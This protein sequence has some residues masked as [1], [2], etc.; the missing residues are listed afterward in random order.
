MM[1][2]LTKEQELI[3]E[4]VEKESVK[5]ALGGDTSYDVEK[6]KSWVDF[7][8][9]LIDLK[10]PEIIICPSPTGIFEVAEK[11]YGYKY[12]KGDVIDYNG[13]GFDS[14]WTSFYIA[15]EKIG[16]DFSDI[17]E[18]SKW[19]LLLETGVWGTRLFEEIAF[20]CLRPSSV[21]VNSND[22]LHCE[23]GKAI[24]WLDG[25][26]F[27]YLNGVRMEEDQVMTPAEKID[28]QEIIKEQ[29]V[30]VRRELIR[31][32]GIE[33]FIQK[34]GAK[35]LDKQ[36]DYKLLSVYLSEQVP[37]TRYLKMKNPSLGTYHVEGVE[38][39]TVEEAIDFR[40]KDILKKGE[41]W[42]PSTLT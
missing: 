3:L 32:V 34:S 40:A 31:K 28:V 16:V 35:V 8:Y 41:K 42:K 20:V 13:L 33:R 38:G 21:K 25:N 2:E 27:F 36:G 30:E 6:I 24:E 15:M 39:N 7:L 19:K 9:E 10:S 1:S 12:K 18:F 29:N 37:D 5:R 11:E 23:N 4:E 26:G 22:D 17:P 14:G